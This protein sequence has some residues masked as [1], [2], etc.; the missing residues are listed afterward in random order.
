MHSVLRM[1]AAEGPF[2]V[3]L[4]QPPFSLV[5]GRPAP[6]TSANGKVDVSEIPRGVKSQ[7]GALVTW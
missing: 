3:K 5:T 1:S 7:E 4:Q 2:H 6:A